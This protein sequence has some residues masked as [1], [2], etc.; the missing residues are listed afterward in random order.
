MVLCVPIFCD[1]VTGKQL[2][3]WKGC[4]GMI[5]LPVTARW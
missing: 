5:E 4:M 3:S 1:W 2:A